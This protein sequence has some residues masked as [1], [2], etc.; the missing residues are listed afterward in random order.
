ME[1]ASSKWPDDFVHV[2]Y[3][4]AKVDQETMLELI[5]DQGIEATIHKPD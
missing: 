3:D 1:K 2:T 4:P 5:R